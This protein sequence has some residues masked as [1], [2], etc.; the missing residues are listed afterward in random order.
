MVISVVGVTVITE[1]TVVVE[2]STLIS[3]VLSCV[4]LLASCVTEDDKIWLEVLAG[5]EPIELKDE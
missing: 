1:K 4:L 2:I 3:V 5:A